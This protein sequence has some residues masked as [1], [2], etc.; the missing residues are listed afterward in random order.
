MVT[1]NGVTIDGVHHQSTK[2]LTVGRQYNLIYMAK[3][4]TYRVENNLREEEEVSASHFTPNYC[5]Q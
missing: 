3:P 1:F 4:D 5:N 2:T